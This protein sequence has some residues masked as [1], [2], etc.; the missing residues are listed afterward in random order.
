MKTKSTIS[1]AVLAATMF[2]S[3]ANAETRWP[4]W[5]VGL[6]GGWSANNSHDVSA[7][8]GT[9]SVGTDDGYLI[10]ASLGYVPPTN[11]PFFDQTRFE[12]E[13]SYRTND[14]DAPA[15]DEVDVHTLMLNMLL[16]I[17]TGTNW[18]PYFGGGLGAARIGVNNDHDSVFAWQLITG[19]DYAP[20]SIPMTVW[21]VRYR[22][23]HAQDADINIGGGVVSEFEFDGHSIEATA[24]FR[25]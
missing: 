4:N 11:V 15:N 12:L 19:L 5:Y 2:A 6:H 22:Y 17:D 9:A 20:T 3:A 23:Q 21:G 10:G 1:L 14:L 13:Y 8:G 16:D 18:T 7:G 24:R 25:F